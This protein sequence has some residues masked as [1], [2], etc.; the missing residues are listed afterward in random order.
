MRY[1]ILDKNDDWLL[2][3]NEVSKLANDA[4]DIV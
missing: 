2:K 4:I 3:D 1:V